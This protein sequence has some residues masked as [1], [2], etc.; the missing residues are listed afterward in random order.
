MLRN[1]FPRFLRRGEGGAPSASQSQVKRRT[2]AAQ[3]ES[4][5]PAPKSPPRPAARVAICRHLRAGPSPRPRAPVHSPGEEFAPQPVQQPGDGVRGSL[6]L[7]LRLR[8]AGPR[9]RGRLHPG[10][11][12]LRARNP[13][14]APGTP[15]SARAQKTGGGVCEAGGAQ[16]CSAPAPARPR[17]GSSGVPRRL[18]RQIINCLARRPDANSFEDYSPARRGKNGAA[19]KGR[20]FSAW[21]VEPRSWATPSPHPRLLR[22]RV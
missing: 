2:P 6:R 22:P 12:S 4:P 16:L 20:L 10:A 15:R 18:L 7:Q 19:E 14:D 21:A 13:S 8:G 11:R 9:R 5:K 3:V 1:A 17:A